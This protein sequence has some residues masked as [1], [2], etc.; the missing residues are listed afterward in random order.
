MLF[1]WGRIFCRG[2]VCSENSLRL[3]IIC[4]VGITN[5]NTT[6]H[7]R[8][9]L[10][11]AGGD[12]IYKGNES[13]WPRDQFNLTADV[14]CSVCH[15]G[16]S[17]CS[18]FLAHFF[19][20]FFQGNAAGLWQKAGCTAVKIPR[21]L[22][23]CLFSMSVSFAATQITC[24][25]AF[26]LS[27]TMMPMLCASHLSK[28]K[29]HKSLDRQETWASSN[30]GKILPYSKQH[31]IVQHLW[32]MREHRAAWNPFRGRWGPGRKRINDL[33]SFPGLKQRWTV[34]QLTPA[35]WWH[36]ESPF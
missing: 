1:P 18:V 13:P 31:Q 27:L 3:T 20:F 16:K 15:C 29:N 4:N 22:A 30:R 21:Y 10:P 35:E 25:N 32:L 12:S 36:G 34:H 23:R 19:F 2:A 28:T 26:Q 17:G 14:I 6:E 24:S 33:K 8:G 5:T 7:F 9:A 11:A